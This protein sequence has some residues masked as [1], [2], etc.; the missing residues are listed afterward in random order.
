M[1][2][3]SAEVA[4]PECRTTARAGAA[5]PIVLFLIA[6]NSRREGKLDASFFSADCCHG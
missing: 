2:L 3:V 4:H 5:K 1:V 6:V